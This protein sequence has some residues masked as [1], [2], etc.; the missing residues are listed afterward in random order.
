MFGAQIGKGA[1]G[2]VYK[3]LYNGTTVAVKVRFEFEATAVTF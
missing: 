1:Y 3:G 2:R